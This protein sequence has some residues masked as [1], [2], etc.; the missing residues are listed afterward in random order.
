[1]AP[2]SLQCLLTCLSPAQGFH[3]RCVPLPYTPTF[4]ELCGAFGLVNAFAGGL[5]SHPCHWNNPWHCVFSSCRRCSGSVKVTPSAFCNFPSHQSMQSPQ[6]VPGHLVGRSY[7]AEYAVHF[8]HLIQRVSESFAFVSS[9]VKHFQVCCCCGHHWLPHAV[10]LL[11]QPLQLPHR[12]FLRPRNHA[13]FIFHFH[14]SLQ[15]LQLLATP[16]HCVDPRRAQPKHRF[17]SRHLYIFGFAQL[18]VRP[19]IVVIRS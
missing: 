8:H 16:R 12:L 13:A 19:P 15:R 6:N 3:E 14:H 18:G 2:L 1:M 5:V 11:L 7:H 9:V 4:Q 17:H 10:Q